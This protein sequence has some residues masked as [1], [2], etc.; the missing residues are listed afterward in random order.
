MGVRVLRG[1]IILGGETQ[2]PCRGARARLPPDHTFEIRTAL[3]LTHHLTPL[4]P[5]HT[6]ETR[7]AL[8]LTH[9]LTPP[10]TPSSHLGDQ[11]SAAP[12]SPPDPAPPSSHL[13]DQDGA[14]PHSPPD[15]C[16]PTHPHTPWR[17]GWRCPPTRT[18]G[19]PAELLSATQPPRPASHPA[20]RDTE[21][22]GER[23][24]RR[25]H[26]LGTGGGEAALVGG[27]RMGGGFCHSA[28]PIGPHYPLWRTSQDLGTSLLPAPTLT[29]Q[30]IP[31]AMTTP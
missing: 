5:H 4:P 9:H 1:E 14:A 29:C 12:H 13:G 24:G 27:R 30:R 26:R 3:L 2:G 19:R 28:V 8:P 10:C 22:W 17:S 6:L 15:P 18:R 16:T 11:D 23:V 7:T 31:S 25:R 20:S 21:T